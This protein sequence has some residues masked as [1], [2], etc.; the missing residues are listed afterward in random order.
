[1]KDTNGIEIK[2]GDIVEIT[3]AYF[4]NDN[5]YWFVDY[6][7]GDPSWSGNE[8]SLKKISKSGKISNSRHNIC[9]WPIM[10]TVNSWEKRAAAKEWNKEHAKIKVVEGIDKTEMAEYFKTKADAAE[11]EAERLTYD[12]GENCETVKLYKKIKN[13]YED[14]IKRIT[15]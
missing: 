2:T 4:K 14:V 9:F 3:G 7:K 15:A 8:H 6:S 12:F 10:I 11:A 5:G 13:H 1:M